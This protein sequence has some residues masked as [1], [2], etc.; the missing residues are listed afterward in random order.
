M[1]VPRIKEFLD[2]HK[3]RY[4]CIPHFPSFTAQGT[5]AVSHTP[6]RN[7][8][9]CVVVNADDD[10]MLAVLCATCQLDLGK[11]RQVTGAQAVVLATEREMAEVVMVAAASAAAWL[12]AQR[13]ANVDAM[14]A[15]RTE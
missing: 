13:A 2:A 7:F 11:M 14:V 6:G 5:A 12:P 3:V 9:K 1:P 10:I 4:E 8:A 15:L